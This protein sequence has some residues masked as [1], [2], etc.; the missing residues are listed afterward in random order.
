MYAFDP[1]LHPDAGGDNELVSIEAG[2]IVSVYD[3]LSDHDWWYVANAKGNFGWV[4]ASYL[5]QVVPGSP[6]CMEQGHDREAEEASNIF[7]EVSVSYI[8]HGLF[9]SIAVCFLER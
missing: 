2:E 7:A 3:A 9:V 5:G 8:A 6:S 1:A 4:P